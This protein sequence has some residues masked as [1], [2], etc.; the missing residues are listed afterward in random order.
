MLYI[1]RIFNWNMVN[2]GGFVCKNFCIY[3]LDIILLYK[4]INYELKSLNK[5]QKYSFFQKF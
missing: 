1:F 2:N 5:L 3:R 4:S